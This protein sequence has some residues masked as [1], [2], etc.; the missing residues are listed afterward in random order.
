MRF[1]VV[2]VLVEIIEEKSVNLRNVILLLFLKFRNMLSHELRS[3]N[4]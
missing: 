3:L 4:R 1:E 2:R